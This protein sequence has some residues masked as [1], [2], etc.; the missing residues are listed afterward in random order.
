VLQTSSLEETAMSGVYGYSNCAM[1]GTGS[2]TGVQVPFPT[3][4]A[5]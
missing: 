3:G 2:F 4:D 5:R 1:S